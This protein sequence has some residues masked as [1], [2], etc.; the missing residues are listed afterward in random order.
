VTTIDVS[1]AV[2][3][4]TRNVREARDALTGVKPAQLTDADRAALSALLDDLAQLIAMAQRL[5]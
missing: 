2:A 3:E 5:E 1:S 4:L